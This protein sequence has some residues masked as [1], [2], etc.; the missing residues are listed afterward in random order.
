MHY[1]FPS[2][3]SIFS[4]LL[5]SLIAWPSLGFILHDLT[6]PS[7]SMTMS[8]TEKGGC[9]RWSSCCCEYLLGISRVL[10]APLH[11]P[12]ICA[13]LLTACSLRPCLRAPC[14]LHRWAQMMGSGHHVSES[15]EAIRNYCQQLF[16]GFYKMNWSTYLGLR[17]CHGS[18]LLSS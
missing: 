9:E 13:R 14:H 3:Y 11:P 7:L 6:C 12:S 4:P 18:I 1:F 16:T 10:P 5:V 2:S 8:E 17:R 15:N